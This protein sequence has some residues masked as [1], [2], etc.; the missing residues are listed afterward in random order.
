MCTCVHVFDVA[1]FMFDIR[2]LTRVLV[3]QLD[4]HVWFG[5]FVL[6]LFV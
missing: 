6:L 2:P 1:V 5:I 4:T 3:H